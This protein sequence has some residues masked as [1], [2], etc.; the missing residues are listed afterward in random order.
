ML[1]TALLAGLA[2]V[3]VAADWLRFE[4]PRSGGGKPLVLLL[5]AIAPALVRPA[6]LRA[7]AVVAS[8]L[9]AGATAFSLSLLD[10]RPG[11]DGF[12]GPLGSRFGNG[13]LDFYDY[14]LP[15]DPAEHERMHMLILAALY[16]FALAVA[17]AVAARRPLIAVVLFLL[18]AGWPA[19]LLAGGNELGRGAV[20]LAVA[21]ALLAGLTGRLGRGAVTAATAVVLGA[22]ALAASPAVAKTAFLDWQHWDFY[23][24]PAKPVP[25]RYVWS[26]DYHGVEFPKKVTTVLRIGGPQ[27]PLYWRATVLERFAADRWLEDIRYE[28][29]RETAAVL[30]RAAGDI[31]NTI[32]QEVTVEA[33]A[34]DHLIGGMIPVAY[35]A[36]EP[37][38]YLGQSVS[39]VR[40][41]LKRG[42]RYS[43]WS[44]APSP[45][46]TQL[47]R[48]RPVYPRV[49]TAPGRELDVAPGVTAAP[50]GT[51][52][53]E[54]ALGAR[55]TGR[56]APYRLL[57]ARAQAVAGRTASPYAAAVALETWFRKTGGFTYSTRPGETPGVPPLV[58]FVTETRT[59]YCQHFAGAMALMLRMLGIPARVGAGFV[60]GKRDR[61]RWLV[62]DHDAH[63]WVEVWFRGYGWLP[64]DPTPGR[65]R[66]SQSY[67]VSSRGFNSA[68][69][70][71]LLAGIV[72]GGEVFGRPGRFGGPPPFD[73]NLRTPRSASDVSSRGLPAPAPEN[74]SHSL[75]QFLALL[76]V[77]IAGAIVLAKTARRRVRYLTR[78]PRRI[79]AAC[80]RELIEFLAD[81][82]VALPTGATFQDLAAAVSAELAVDARPFTDAAAS[83]RFGP[84]RD[85]SASARRAREE[86]RHLK[87]RLRGRM[88]LLDRV[89]GLLSLRSLGFS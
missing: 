20:I 13:F 15:I 16:G 37:V 56:L 33:L 78:D 40:G 6:W 11:G 3:V 80:A 26:S 44:Y 48:S 17:L 50:F 8:L 12:F 14:R 85:A 87:R 43:I 65:G 66:L 73:P 84:P 18:A 53:A 71:R 36:S 46:P 69:A 54:R 55:L 38:R 2:G 81:Q 28:S 58:G 10:L 76:A 9:A 68:A 79:A 7:V 52:G 42:Q 67:S 34:D 23:N 49:L 47:V 31:R 25:V 41:G 21:L 86:L 61:G 5:L 74:R 88:L 1:K 19:T 63:T 30:P 22:L 62:T 24:R 77:A 39:V 60:S 72:S 82:R 75:V 57:L 70:A 89:R 45:T 35:D 27:T 83:A 29:R 59:G 64:F 4:D 51:P 32:R